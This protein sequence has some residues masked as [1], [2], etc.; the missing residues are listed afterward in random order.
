MVILNNICI[1]LKV[2]KL[3]D[4][5]QQNGMHL[6][7]VCLIIPPLLQNKAVALQSQPDEHFGMA[8]ASMLPFQTKVGGYCHTLYSICSPKA[9]PQNS[10]NHWDHEPRIMTQYKWKW[11]VCPTTYKLYH[12][13]HNRW[14]IYKPHNLHTAILL[15]N[16]AQ[17]SWTQKPYQTTQPH[18]I[19]RHFRLL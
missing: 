1:A 11:Q 13:Q 8:T 2:K 12:L 3:V 19:L 15:T 17:K 7:P 14:M 6:Q 9:W 10:T 4:I 5:T 18:S 16:T